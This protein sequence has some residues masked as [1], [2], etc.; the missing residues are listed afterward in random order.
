[1]RYAGFVGPSYTSQNP[2]AA[3][4]RAVNW[5]PSRIESGTGKAAYQYLPAPG[6]SLYCDLGVSSPIRGEFTL[7]GASFAVAGGTLYQLPFTSGGTAVTLATGITN[8]DDSLVSM[9][10]NGDGG[11][12]IVIGSA[13]LLYCYDVRAMTL[14]PITGVTGTSV[15]FQDGYFI[16]LDPTTSNIYL[17]A[18]ED[19]STWDPLDVAQRSDL[20]DKWQTLFTSHGELWLPGSQTGSVYYDSGA[21]F[22]FSPNPAGKLQYGVLAAN[23]AQLVDGDAIWLASN[24]AGGATVVRAQGYQLQRVSTHATEYAWSQY[25]TLIDADAF[26]YQEQGHTFYCLNFPSTDASWVYD[27]TEGLWHERGLWN[28]NSF[29]VLPVRCH[30]YANNTHLVGDRSTGKIWQ[31]SS[32]VF[33]DTDGQGMVRMRRAPHLCTELSRNRYAKFQLDMEVGVALQTGQGSDPQVM[34]RWSNDGGQS[35]GNIIT[36]SAGPI[37]QYKARVIWRRLGMARDRVFEVTVSDQI[38]WRI[39]DAYLDVIPGAA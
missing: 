6:F 12:Q 33:T 28:G 27:A 5:Y 25:S 34:L 29:G 10:G 16:A 26:T 18:L 7:N 14:T 13:G 2:I 30:I 31:M 32:D 21:D 9:A 4:D 1:M 35:F 15:V 8:P 36:A 23:T 17:S 20:P 39:V 37:G 19:G 11:F 22:P 3:D 38:P 24:A